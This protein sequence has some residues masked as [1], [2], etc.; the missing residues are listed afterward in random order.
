MFGEGDDTP[1]DQQTDPQQRLGDPQPQPDRD[2]DRQP[3]TEPRDA[4][5]MSLADAARH[6]RLD[7]FED[8][9]GSSNDTPTDTQQTMTG[10]DGRTLQD[11]INEYGH[12]DVVEAATGAGEHLVQLSEQEISQL[13]NRIE[14]G[15]NKF[16]VPLVIEDDGLRWTIDLRP[17]AIA[18]WV[19]PREVQVAIKN[20]YGDFGLWRN[21]LDLPDRRTADELV[22][23]QL[24]LRI[25]PDG[26][27]PV[28]VESVEI[29]PD[30]QQPT[31]ETL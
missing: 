23:G 22:I 28:P 6:K 15:D 3:D 18:E 12:D 1:T 2:R 4:G 25:A 17:D 14:Q 21:R 13:R 10:N 7:A 9:N 31:Q 26:D 24:N 16:S 8:E 5:Q 27:K 29:H 19:F 11:F 30:Y 20:Q